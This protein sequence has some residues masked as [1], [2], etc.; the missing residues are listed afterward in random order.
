M[1]IS[2]C[3]ST[4]LG[5][6]FL[7]VFSNFTRFFS[8]RTLGSACYGGAKLRLELELSS[9]LR[10]YRSFLHS[11]HCIEYVLFYSMFRCSL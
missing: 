4:V 2:A 5:A 9:G 3:I 6:S 10:Y 8:G 11:L 1:M 7:V